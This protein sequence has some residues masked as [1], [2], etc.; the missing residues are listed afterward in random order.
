M[1]YRPTFFY[2]A[3][4]KEKNGSKG[5]IVK[6]DVNESKALE[7]RNE[8]VKH[9]KN[10]LEENPNCH[11][12]RNVLPIAT[13]PIF[14]VSKGGAKRKRHTIPRFSQYTTEVVKGK[15]GSDGLVHFESEKEQTALP[16]PH[17]GV[18]GPPGIDCHP[19]PLSSNPFVVGEF[20]DETAQ[21]A[22]NLAS[23]EDIG[24]VGLGISFRE[25]PE[26]D[27]K[28]DFTASTLKALQMMDDEAIDAMGSS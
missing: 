17:P 21:D 5:T 16:L 3:H 23:E 28:D 15:I 25:H 8:H 27:K 22:R 26:A 4:D 9:V 18:K 1:T 11:V 7:M 10:F 12:P 19:H 20:D 6:K 13:V 14:D 24:K 2:N